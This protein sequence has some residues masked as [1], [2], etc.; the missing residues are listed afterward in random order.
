MISVFLTT[1]F[2][3]VDVLVESA[4][5]LHSSESAAESQ[6][7]TLKS[8]KKWSANPTPL[9]LASKQA[10]LEQ[11]SSSYSGDFGE[12]QICLFGG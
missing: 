6:L 4:A 8:L 11:G 3:E 12:E 2:L 5:S 9:V 7:S 1:E 10:R